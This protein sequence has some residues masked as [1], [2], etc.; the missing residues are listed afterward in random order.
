MQRSQPSSNERLSKAV[1]DPVAGILRRLRYLIV[2]NVHTVSGT[3]VS[4]SD[5]TIILQFLRFYFGRPNESLNQIGHTSFPTCWGEK[6]FWEYH[7]PGTVG[8]RDHGRCYG[9]SKFSR[10]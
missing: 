8:S 3:A 2:C 9:A 4:Q 6:G 5:S 1:S 7:E 10:Q